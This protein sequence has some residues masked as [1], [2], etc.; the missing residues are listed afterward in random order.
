MSIQSLHPNLPAAYLDDQAL[1]IS[2][3][4]VTQPDVVTHARRQCDATG[5]PDL[6]DWTEATLTL[7]AKAPGRWRER[8]S[9]STNCDGPSPSS[10]TT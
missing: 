4:V 10:P 6:G 1:V 9:T 7:G 8:P 3:L 5:D 2:S